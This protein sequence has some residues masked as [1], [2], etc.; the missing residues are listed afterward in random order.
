MS[1]LSEF[2]RL[3]R[4]I[5]E[6]TRKPFV[7][8]ENEINTLQLNIELEQI[9]FKNKFDFKIEVESGLIPTEILIPPML[10]QPYVEN[11]I[12]HGLLK[13]KDK[14]MLTISYSTE[15]NLLICNIND[16]GIGR[17][18][19]AK[20]NKLHQAGHKSL[21]MEVTGERIDILKK[22]GKENIEATISDLKDK[23]NQACGTNVE[24][25]IPYKTI[26]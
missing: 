23:N 2:A 19:S 17:E 9:R 14:G 11:V 21:G 26:N 5:L 18:A 6:N 4:L 25:K 1:Y 16:N 20:L 15:N 13:L 12:K 3:M 22:Q 8:L 10:L 24:L 7:T